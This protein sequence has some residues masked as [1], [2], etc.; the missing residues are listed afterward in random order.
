LALSIP[1]RPVLLPSTTLIVHADG[2]QVAAVEKN[3]VHRRKAMLGRD[4]GQ[5]IEVTGRVTDKDV[6]VYNLQD[7]ARE[8][9]PAPISSPPAQTK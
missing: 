8:G 3:T 5:Q 1:A 9:T 6:I 2:P 4:L 7:L